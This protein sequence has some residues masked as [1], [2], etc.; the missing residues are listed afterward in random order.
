MHPES[1]KFGQHF[2]APYAHRLQKTRFQYI[3]VE[4]TQSCSFRDSCL[5]KKRLLFGDF[6]LENG[7]ERKTALTHYVEATSGARSVSLFSFG[8]T[9]SCF[10]VSLLLHRQEPDR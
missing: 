10:S 9:V 7:V 4:Q 6:G 3:K 2:D 5:F 1:F 8:V